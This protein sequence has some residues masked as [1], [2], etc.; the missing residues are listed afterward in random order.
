MISRRTF[1]Q[2][3][4]AAAALAASGRAKTLKTVGVQLYT[5]RGVLPEKPAETLRAID[6]I[7]YREIEGTQGLLDKIVSGLPGTKLKPVSLHLDSKVVTQ[8]SEDDLARVLDTVKKAGY[9]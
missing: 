9:T 2:A 7:G 1:L 4:S 6:A 5:V 8:G 3:G